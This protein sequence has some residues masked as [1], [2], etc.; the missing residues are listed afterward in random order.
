MYRTHAAEN[1]CAF[2]LVL[3]VIM[4]TRLS[5]SWHAGAVNW[6]GLTVNCGKLGWFDGKLTDAKNLDSR[7]EHLVST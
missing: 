6:A 1:G 2:P 7:N 5:M 4:G 3:M